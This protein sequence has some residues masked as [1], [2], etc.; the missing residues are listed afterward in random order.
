MEWTGYR[1]P[2]P[3][4]SPWKKGMLAFS[5]LNYQG[6]MGR[7][8]TLEKTLMLGKVQGGRRRGATEDEMVGWHH[9]FNGRECEQAPGDEGQGSLVCC[10]SWGHKESDM[11]ERLNR[12]EHRTFSPKEPALTSSLLCKKNQSYF[13]LNC[14]H[15]WHHIAHNVRKKHPW[16]DGEVSCFWITGVPSPLISLLLAPAATFWPGQPIPLGD[17][18]AQE[19]LLSTTAATQMI[20]CG[21]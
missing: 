16:R 20:G 7:A 11:T 14:L 17:S 6:L 4:F 5:S 1:L 3:A 13:P 18:K 19:L 21:A 9:W 12:T 15:V 10:S 8:D 2:A